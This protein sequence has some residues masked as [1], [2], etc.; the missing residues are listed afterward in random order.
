[1]Q[2]PS[3]GK[4]YLPENY[5]FEINKSLRQIERRG[6]KRVALQFPEGLMHYS[7]VVSDILRCEGGVDVIIMSDVVYGAC[8]IDDVSALLLKCDL[9][10]H[11]GHSCLIEVS[12]SLVPAMYV[13]V[14][15]KVDIDHCVNLCK[16]HL[17]G[18][19]QSLAIMGTVQYN[20]VVRKI[21]E[22]L[23]R[24]NE[25][26]EREVGESLSVPRIRPLSTGEVLGCTSPRIKEEAL[27]F[28][29]E[30]RFHL[31]S[32]MISNPSVRFFRYCP[33]SK[34]M[35]EEKHD[36]P[37]FISIR[38]EKVKESSLVRRFTIVFGTLGRQGSLKILGRIEKSLK[39]RG[40]F[41]RVL[42]VSEI[43]EELVSSVSKES[44]G[45]IEIACPRIAIDWGSTFP[46]PIITPYEYF[47]TLSSLPET[48]P[49]DYYS[50]E[51]EEDWNN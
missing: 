11:Y 5:N 41:Y 26:S 31:E 32:L 38:R 28:I 37:R 21:K 19:I 12:K 47:C 36:Y 13:F 16:A 2:R 39:E 48:Y 29:S 1:M 35:S 30:G 14:D 18:N 3:A 42:F 40:V 22:R 23:S 7:T 45:I 25:I 24:R 46:I 10:I 27:L 33:S 17:L 8:C 9:L 34:I 6:S 50:R 51:K 15:I 20:G 43:D 44:E 4:R 49:M